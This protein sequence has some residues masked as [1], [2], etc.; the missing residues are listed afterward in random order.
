MNMVQTSSMLFKKAYE[1]PKEQ[2]RTLKRQRRH[3]ETTKKELNNKF[4]KYFLIH[5]AM[6]EKFL[7]YQG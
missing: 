5:W 4:G 7:K 1:D 2:E 6:V 3:L